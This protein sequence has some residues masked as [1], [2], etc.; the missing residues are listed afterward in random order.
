M[1]KVSLKSYEE[2]VVSEQTAQNILV[3]LEEKKNEEN[4]G[5]L[6]LSA[7]P[8]TIDHDGGM[9]F[10][11]LSNISQIHL[12]NQ[13][14]TRKYDFKNREDVERFH[15]DFGYGA[16]TEEVVPGYGLLDVKTKFLIKTNQA[17]LRDS[18]L[19]LLKVDKDVAEKWSD[20]WF[21]YEQKLDPF[22]ELI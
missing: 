15:N 1:A 14:K 22:F 12:S 9:W 13:Q 8:L 2:L 3:L 5:G 19:V 11:N 20:L 16:F 4:S 18:R 17:E 10:G 7:W 6:P 21:S